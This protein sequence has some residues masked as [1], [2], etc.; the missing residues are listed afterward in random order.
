MINVRAFSVDVED[1]ADA[2]RL[3]SVDELRPS[4]C[5]GCS[6]AA[7]PAS[8][9]LGLVG[10]GTYQRQVRGLSPGGWVTIYVRRYLCT[11]CKRT[12]SVL[13]NVLHP[14]F[15]YSA[16]AIL[17]ALVGSVLSGRSNADLRSS[18]GP[19]DRRPHWTS[20][21]RWAEQLGPRLWSWHA[22]ELGDADGVPRS[23]F[24]ER[25]LALAGCH[26]RSPDRALESAVT[27]LAPLGG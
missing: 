14:G 1:L 21:A 4:A 23:E 15:W 2:T 12:T 9:Q 8:G 22:A 25:L 11:R 24:L 16:A 20:P 19:G 6:N 13:P 3:P 10:H 27:K 26:A 18:L 17:C 5:P 7:H